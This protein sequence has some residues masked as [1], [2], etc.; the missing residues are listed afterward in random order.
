MLVIAA[1]GQLG[2]DVAGYFGSGYQVIPYRDVELDITDEERVRA[3]F[4]KEKPDIVVNCAAITNVDGCEKNSELAFA[5][6]G[7]GA[8]IVGRAAAEIGAVLVHISTDYVFD[9]T[10][11]VPRKES[12][13]V[14]PNTVYGKSKLEGE[15]EIEKACTK[16]FILRTAWL[17]GPHAT[18]SFVKT[19]LRVGVQKKELSVVNDQ[20]GNPTSTAELVRIIEA[21]LKTDK[22]GVYHATCE[23]ICS[24]NDFAR[25]IFRLAKMDVAVRGVTTA[26]YARM[27][28]GAAP[29]PA[30]SA[31]SKDKLAAE[32]GYRPRDWKQ[33]L[34]EYFAAKQ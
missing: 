24:W 25:E 16:Y 6:N 5:V 29:R 17:Y 11:I 27:V 30:F 12:D 9:G 19:M 7:K 22:Y 8:G 10:G 14:G 33:A 15:R 3:V 1:N 32:C 13:P 26:E 4:G 18:V 31:L 21:V 2:T 28:P 23:G 20:L 34:A